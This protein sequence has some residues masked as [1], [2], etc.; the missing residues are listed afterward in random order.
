MQYRATYRAIR[1][2]HSLGQGILAKG[3]GSWQEAVLTNMLRMNRA[4]VGNGFLSH[5]KKLGFKH[6]YNF[7]KVIVN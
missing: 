5:Q 7:L 2:A 6:W 3:Q 4:A 1:K